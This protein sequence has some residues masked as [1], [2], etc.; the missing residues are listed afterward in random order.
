MDILTYLGL[1]FRDASLKILFY[2]VV[3]AIIIPKIII[4]YKYKKIKSRLNHISLIKTPCQSEHNETN[5]E[6]RVCFHS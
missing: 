4:V 1:N 6:V 5:R 3:L 2:L